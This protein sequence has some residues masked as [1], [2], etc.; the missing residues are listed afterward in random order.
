MW[1][2]GYGAVFCSS[3]LGA[4]AVSGTPPPTLFPIAAILLA[5]TYIKSIP[6]STSLPRKSRLIILVLK[7]AKK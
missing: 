5:P 2:S 6:I 4:S 1:K 3:T 7:S